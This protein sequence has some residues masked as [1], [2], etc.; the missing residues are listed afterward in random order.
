[1]AQGRQPEF[2]FKPAAGGLVK[3]LGP[4]ETKNHADR[5]ARKIY[6]R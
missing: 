5:V 4:L 2:R 1:M 3:V 6:H